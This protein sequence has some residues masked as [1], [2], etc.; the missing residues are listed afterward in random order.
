MGGGRLELVWLAD[1]TS[2]LVQAMLHR[3]KL[4]HAG[5]GSIGMQG[6]QGDFPGQVCELVRDDLGVRG[7]GCGH[8]SII[9]SQYRRRHLNR[10]DY[11]TARTRSST[12]ART[13]TAPDVASDRATAWDSDGARRP[14]SQCETSPD[15]TPSRRASAADLVAVS[16]SQERSRSGPVVITHIYPW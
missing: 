16:S 6:A 14:V 15:V 8:E 10:P 9:Y 7:L 3:A 13:G 4:G 5:R 2:P 1:G 12:H 11:F